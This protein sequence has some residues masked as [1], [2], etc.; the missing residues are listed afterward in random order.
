MGTYFVINFALYHL[1][2]RAKWLEA[3]L[4]NIDS[5]KFHGNP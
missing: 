3:W 4:E 1:Q 2:N 5:A